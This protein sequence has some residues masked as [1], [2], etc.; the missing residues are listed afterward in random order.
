MKPKIGQLVTVYG[1][2]CQIVAVH[3]FGTIDVVSLDGK[4]AYRFSGL[5]F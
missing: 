5:A 1:L 2:R 4:Y 3:P